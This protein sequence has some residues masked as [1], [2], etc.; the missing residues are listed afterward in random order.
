LKEEKLKQQNLKQE[1]YNEGLVVFPNP[2]NNK[3]TLR[4]SLSLSQHVKLEVKD[5]LGRN[6][7]TL[8]DHWSAPGNY[9]IEIFTEQF[10]TGT[11]LIF[12][13]NGQKKGGQAASD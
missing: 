5:L 6:I 8:A 7:L 10:R 13:E 2:A 11:Y 12:F 3:A 9:E 1:E 4:Y